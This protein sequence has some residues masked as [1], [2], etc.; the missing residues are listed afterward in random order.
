M[1][2]RSKGL[3][4]AAFAPSAMFYGQDPVRNNQ[5]IGRHVGKILRGAK[6]SD[7]PVDE[8]GHIELVINLKTAKMLGLAVPKSL[9]ARADRVF[10]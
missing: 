9:L 3:W 7:L 2:F 4:I 5:L 10:E 8:S 1:A 6:P